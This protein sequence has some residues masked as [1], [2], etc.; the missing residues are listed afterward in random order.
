MPPLSR[1]DEQAIA[2]RIVK[3][4]SQTPYALSS[5]SQLHGG[6]ANFV[7][8][9]TL[10]RRLPAEDES[11]ATTVIIKHSTEFVAI[12]RDFPLDVTRCVIATN[13]P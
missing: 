10:A 1:A 13:F 11:I 4:L 12:N 8:R 6:T 5:I 2:D 7:F 3:E 9:G